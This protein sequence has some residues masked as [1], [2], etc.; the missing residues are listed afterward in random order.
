[1]I[2]GLAGLALLG[3]P[4]A[5]RS[6]AAQKPLWVPARQAEEPNVIGGPWA[7]EGPGPSHGGQVEGIPDLPVTGAV[8]ALAPHPGDPNVLYLGAVNGGLWKTTDATAANPAWASLTDGF[9]SLSIGNSSLRFDP[10]DV[11]GNTLVAGIGRSSSFGFVGGARIGLLRTTDAGSSWTLLDGAGVLVGK[12]A[13]G[14]AA[15]GNVIV[16]AVN[17][18]DSG[19]LTAIGIFRSTDNGASFVLVSGTGGLPLGRAFGLAED[20][21]NAAVLYTAIRDAGVNNGVYKST[22]TGTTW[23]RVSDAAINALFS[24]T[25]PTTTNVKLAVGSADNPYVA[26]A[27]SGRLVGLFR[28]GNGGGTWTSLALPVTI[29]G[30]VPHGIH[31]GGQAA[32][33]FSMAASP[34]NPN[35]VYIGGDRQPGFGDP[36][37]TFPNSLGAQDY[38][39]RLFRV[40]ASLP[41]G[42]QAQH[43]THSSSLG[44]PGGGT[45]NGSAPHADSRVLAV[46][47]NGDVLEGDDGGVYK[48]TIPGNDTGIWVSVIGTLVSTEFHGIGFDSNTD[49]VLGGTQDNGTPQQQVPDDPTW[50]SISTGD[51]GDVSVDDSTTAGLSVR[52][53]SYQF[54]GAFARRTYDSANNLLSVT[55]PPLTPVGGPAINP[56]FYSAVKVNDLVQTRLVIAGSNG[57]FESLNQGDTVAQLATGGPCM[58]CFAS[59]AGG[60]AWTA[61]TCCTSGRRRCSFAPSLAGPAEPSGSRAEHETDGA[62]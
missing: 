26:I 46:D 2:A 17:A 43:L 42:S 57:T 34:S 56:Q 33:H 14:V 45:A 55:F 8:N 6:L 59:A 60:W 62:T 16:A 54:L 32:W 44:P 29:E 3:P 38:S 40:D 24:D 9:G 18:A 49:T 27:N 51:G 11:T 1:V 35:V 37:G 28:S 7:G 12:N 30:G 23:V 36:G 47:A 22:D 50:A 53:T 31:V 48:R 39:G 15:R 19:G 10:T 20:P 41:P 52:Y 21:Q 4:L 5:S 58:N 25:A 61:P 13:A